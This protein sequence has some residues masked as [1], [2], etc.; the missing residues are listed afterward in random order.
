M[1]GLQLFGW[2][3]IIVLVSVAAGAIWLGCILLAEGQALKQAIK[4]VRCAYGNI[5]IEINKK[6]LGHNA[7]NYSDLLNIVKYVGDRI[8]SVD[9]TLDRDH[10]HNRLYI[11]IESEGVTSKMML[12]TTVI[13]YGVPRLNER[14]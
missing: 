7:L 8:P 3:V 12:M 9:I 13:E 11:V 14:V 4:D 10:E 1:T 6:L 2:I 5:E